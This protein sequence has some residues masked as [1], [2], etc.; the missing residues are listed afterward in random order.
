MKSG[1]WYDLKMRRDSGFWLEMPKEE[2]V[3]FGLDLT[4]PVSLAAALRAA[5]ERKT[6]LA[7]AAAISGTVVLGAWGFSGDLGFSL[8]VSWGFTRVQVQRVRAGYYLLTQTHH[9]KLICLQPVQT[10]I[11]LKPNRYPFF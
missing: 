7:A 3:R 6:D 4:P 10:E 5:V 9:I 1:D 8:Q 2:K 11:Q